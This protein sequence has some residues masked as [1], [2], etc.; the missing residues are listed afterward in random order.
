MS[1]T[2][3]VGLFGTLRVTYQNIKRKETSP[4][5]QWSRLTSS[6]NQA[7]LPK[8]EGLYFNVDN[9]YIEGAVRSYRNGLLTSQ[10]YMNVTQCETLDGKP[11]LC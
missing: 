4:T 1:K 11:T 7:L 6:L 9:R 3:P 5:L 8:I 10:N 2:W